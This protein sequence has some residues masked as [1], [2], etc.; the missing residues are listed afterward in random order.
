LF[1]GDEA[2]PAIRV[3]NIIRQIAKALDAAHAQGLIHRDVKPANIL[4]DPPSG[5]SEP[6]SQSTRPIDHAYLSDFGVSRQTVAS[7]L[8][9]TG[10]FVGT[11]DYIAP[12]QIEGQLIDGRAD[13]YSLACTAYELLT[14]SVPFQREHSLA[15]ISAHLTAPPPSVTASRRD[16]PASINQVITRAMAKVPAQRYLTCADFA[17]E[18]SRALLQ[19]TP[20]LLS[21]A[22]VTAVR[23]QPGSVAPTSGGQ[24]RPARRRPIRAIVATA[25][26]AALVVTSSIVLL[27]ISHKPGRTI[28]TAQIQVRAMNTV[29][30]TSTTSRSALPGLISNVSQCQDLGRAAARLQQIANERSLELSKA[31]GLRVTAIAGGRALKSMLIRAL[32]VSLR[33]D[34]DYALWAKL[35]QTN[36]PNKTG[37][38]YYNEAVQ[39]DIAA[40][41]AK[42]A[43]ISTWNSVAAQ[44]GYPTNPAF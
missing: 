17:D 36:C 27:A 43:F 6:S 20:T 16:L 28:P 42:Q 32:K 4:L 31:E 23:P 1:A 13:Q 21:S 3:A 33:T 35:R 10:Q 12:E 41:A 34:L 5:A 24:P 26:A 9:S 11:L 37:Q 44:Y 25:T 14:G 2:R 30:T 22:A 39:G 38:T 19:L 15:V 29:L 18:L 7:H 40:T 8:T